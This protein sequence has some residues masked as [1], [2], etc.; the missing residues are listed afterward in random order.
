MKEG[1]DSLSFYNLFHSVGEDPFSFYNLF[2]STS[3]VVDEFTKNLKKKAKEFCDSVF[4]SELHEL[5]II[6]LQI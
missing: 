6:V 3:I 1:V 2:H 4:T 5:N